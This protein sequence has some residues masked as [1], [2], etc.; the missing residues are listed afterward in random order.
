MIY[1]WFIQ[2]KGYFGSESEILHL[3][4]ANATIKYGGI[5]FKGTEIE[6]ETYLK[7]LYKTEDSFKVIGVHKDLKM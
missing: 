6:L 2:G 4:F 3:R 5:D 7:E 1:N